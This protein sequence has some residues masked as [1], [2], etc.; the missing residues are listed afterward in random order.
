MDRTNPDYGETPTDYGKMDLDYGE[1]LTRE[2]LNDDEVEEGLDE[3]E[4]DVSPFAVSENDE[5]S[6]IPLDKWDNLSH[7]NYEKKNS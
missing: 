6:D 1:T 4:A 3:D 5:M 7:S 2:G